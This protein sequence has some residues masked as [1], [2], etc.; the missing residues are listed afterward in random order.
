K[1]FRVACEKLTTARKSAARSL[2]E[3]ITTLMQTLGM[4]GG[5]FQIDVRPADAAGVNGA[6]DI[7]FL[8]SANPGQPPRPLAKVA[9][10]GE[11]S[12]ISLAIQ[13][14]AVQTDA[15]AG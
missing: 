7:E 1:K 3:S 15:L 9:S 6:D 10:G 4:P 11:L 13:V 14:A 2:G 12:R 8:V 5:K